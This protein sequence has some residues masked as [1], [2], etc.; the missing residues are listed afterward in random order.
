M[1]RKNTPIAPAVIG[2]FFG[3]IVL[4]KAE[5][6]PTPEDAGPPERYVRFAQAAATGD[7]SAQYEFGKMNESGE[8]GFV[9]YD[10]AI[11]WYLKAARQGNVEAQ[12]RLG[13][14]YRRRIGVESNFHEAVKWYRMAARQGHV[15]SLNSLGVMYD[16]GEDYGE[17]QDYVEAYKWFS[18]AIV[19]GNATAARNRD[20]IAKWMTAAQ[21]EQAVAKINTWQRAKDLT[22]ARDE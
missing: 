10:T 6:L 13:Y 8:A 9:D 5:R 12:Y 20:R 22:E 11:S 17:P 4:A 7:P 1:I 16:H 14:M 18:L 3:M 15:G 2:L 19:Q 21:I